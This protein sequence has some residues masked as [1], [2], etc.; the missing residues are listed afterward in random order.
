MLTTAFATAVIA[1]AVV[2][3]V[4]NAPDIRRYMKMRS[5]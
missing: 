4:K 1:A 5:M 3:A 2:V